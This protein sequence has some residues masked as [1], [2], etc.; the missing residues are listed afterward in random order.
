MTISINFF[1]NT[2]RKE[3]VIIFKPEDKQEMIKRII[4]RQYNQLDEICQQ[5]L[6]EIDDLTAAFSESDGTQWIEVQQ[7]R[8][9]IAAIQSEVKFKKQEIR[10]LEIRARHDQ[11]ISIYEQ[12]SQE[13]KLLETLLENRVL[14][15]S[16]VIEA[17]LQ[18]ASGLNKSNKPQQTS[19]TI[20]NQRLDLTGKT[21]KQPT[22]GNNYSDVLK[23]WQDSL[24][25]VNSSGEK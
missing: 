4:V 2:N 9:L 23:K 8:D 6:A 22:G 11:L 21:S 16:T 5:T 17:N 3:G 7:T 20:N 13:V 19:A 10:R 15:E 18:G 1:I 25:K 14:T 24:K 12:T